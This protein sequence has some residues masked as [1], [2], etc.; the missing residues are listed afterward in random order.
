MDLNIFFDKRLKD[1]E[2]DELLLLVYVY[3]WIV[4]DKFKDIILLG[5]RF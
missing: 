4:L 2:I 5:N 3:E 1:S